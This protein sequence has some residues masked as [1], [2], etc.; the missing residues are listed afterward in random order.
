MD[1]EAICRAIDKNADEIYVRLRSYIS[2]MTSARGLPAGFGDADEIIHEA[3]RRVLSGTRS[4]DPTKQSIVMIL[5]GTVRSLL[6]KKKGLYSREGK[7]PLGKIA[8]DVEPAPEGQDEPSLSEEE[9]LL[10][11]AAVESVVG[12]DKELLDYFAAVRLGYE[13]PAEIAEAMGVPVERVYEIP[14]KLERLAPRIRERFA[15]L[16][17]K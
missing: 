17:K 10:R 5:Y 8:A 12:D 4:F 2:R 11:W 6:S 13:K 7:K 3:I 1:R 15:E 16:D 14:R 9:A